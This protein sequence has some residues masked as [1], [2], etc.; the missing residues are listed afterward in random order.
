MKKGFCLALT[1]LLLLSAL[2]GCAQQAD[3]LPA[4]AAASQS[5]ATAAATPTPAPVEATA[6]P[7]PSPTPVEATA[8]PAPSEGPFRFT[9]ENFPE[10]DGSTACVPMAEAICSVLLG[11]DRDAVQ[12]LVRF[13]RT[14]A[15]FRNL[16][17]NRCGLILA[18]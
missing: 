3:E 11:E 8:A 7:T 17:E 12:D 5:P 18:S 6:E 13:N 10:L 2:G 1:L 4:P 14:T 9:R 16:M 15:S